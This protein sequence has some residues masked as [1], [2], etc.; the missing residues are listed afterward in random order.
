M[1]SSPGSAQDAFLVT[2]D[3]FETGLALMRQNL[4]RAEP[5]ATDDDIDRRLREWL[6]H[7]PGAET[8]DCVGRPLPLDGPLNDRA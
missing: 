4:K 8:G 7:R 6:R 5:D 1:P 3:L 2:L